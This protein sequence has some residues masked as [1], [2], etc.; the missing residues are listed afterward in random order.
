MLAEIVGSDFNGFSFGWRKFSL[1]RD[2]CQMEIEMLDIVKEN[3]EIPNFRK[4]RNIGVDL[5]YV[6]HSKSP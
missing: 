2:L 4:K 5:S 1:S 3:A 6:T